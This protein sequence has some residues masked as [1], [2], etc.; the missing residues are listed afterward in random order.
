M[1]A[2]LK[3]IYERIKKIY[4]KLKPTIEKLKTLTAAITKVVSA[5]R[6]AQSMVNAT[7]AIQKRGSTSTICL[8]MTNAE[9]QNTA[10]MT[11]DVY[12]ATKQWYVTV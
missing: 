5:I 4:E 3:A 2:T 11:L 8:P 6:Q 10:D 12:N 1:I 7:D 9:H